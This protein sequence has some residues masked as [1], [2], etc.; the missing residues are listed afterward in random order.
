[1]A[2]QKLISPS[3]NPAHKGREEDY[4]KPQPLAGCGFNKFNNLS[5]YNPATLRFGDNS[6]KQFQ[7]DTLLK[8]ESHCPTSLRS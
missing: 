7:Y 8:W 5:F 2:E 3:L 1:L 4:K 6:T